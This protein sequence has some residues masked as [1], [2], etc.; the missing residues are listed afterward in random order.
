MIVIDWKLNLF[1]NQQHIQW[2]FACKNC[3]YWIKNVH[4]YFDVEMISEHLNI[5]KV[6]NISE[7]CELHVV[8]WIKF[9]SHTWSIR[10]W[11]SPPCCLK[12]VNIDYCIVK[13][14]PNSS[15]SKKRTERVSFNKIQTQSHLKTIWKRFIRHEKSEK[16]H[17]RWNTLRKFCLRAQVL[18][19]YSS[20]FPGFI[21]VW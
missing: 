9:V 11:H 3:I 7:H 21:G 20:C 16:S 19:V 15:S 5:D 13:N 6:M 18:F 17:G 1:F 2:F 14:F 12:M 8:V 10:L 4:K